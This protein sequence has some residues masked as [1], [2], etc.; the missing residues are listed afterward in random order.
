MFFTLALSADTAE[1]CAAL[2]ERAA[3]AEPSLMPV[4]GPVVTA[5]RSADGRAALLHWGSPEGRSARAEGGVRAASRA[6]TIWA[7]DPA[8]DGPAA[9][10]GARTAITRVDPVYLAE[11]PGAVVVADRATWAAWTA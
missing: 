11:V 1:R 7:A 5:W 10:L 6:G 8:A 2:T 4:P 3:A 9:V